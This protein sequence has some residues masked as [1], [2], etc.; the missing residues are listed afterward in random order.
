MASTSIINNTDNNNDINT[1]NDEC[2][3]CCNKY[4]ARKYSKIQC[5]YCNYDMCRQCLEKYLLTTNDFINCMKCKNRWDINFLSKYTSKGF[6][7]NKYKIHR[8]KVL[9]DKE[10]SKIPDIMPCVDSYN[11]IQT[12]KKIMKKTE[13]LKYF[14]ETLEHINNH[15]SFGE[16]NT[17]SIPIDNIRLLD[18]EVDKLM[19]YMN[20]IFVKHIPGLAPP[21]PINV[22]FNYAYLHRGPGWHV[23]PRRITEYKNK[24]R[25]PCPTDNCNSFLDDNYECSVCDCKI[26]KYCNAILDNSNNHVCNK[27]DIE[28]VKN[29]RKHA[30]SCPKCAIPIFKISGCDQMWCTGCKTGF[31]WITGKITNTNIHNPHY[32]NWHIQEQGNG[33]MVIQGIQDNQLNDV[34]CGT[35]PLLTDWIGAINNYFHFDFSY[36]DGHVNY[37]TLTYNQNKNPYYLDIIE[38]HRLAQQFGDNILSKLRRQYN[39]TKETMNFRIKFVLNQIDEKGLKDILIKKDNEGLLLLPQ[40]EIYELFNTV[41]IEIINDVYHTMINNQ[42]NEYDSRI[43]NSKPKTDI[44]KDLHKKRIKI[45]WDK[46]K[47]INKLITYANEQICIV[48]KNNN[49]KAVYFINGDFTNKKTTIS[50]RKCEV[51][52]RRPYNRKGKNGRDYMIYSYISKP[53][54]GTMGYRGRTNCHRD[55]L[56]LGTI[57]ES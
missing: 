21:I 39:D 41:I 44:Q 7:K 22:M 29:I 5:H 36:N 9:Y 37:Y 18:K 25:K 28:S 43:G 49:N 33:N 57:Y 15:Y 3:V 55:H 56:I 10:V 4:T 38:L 47:K 20:N 40:L 2:S 32:Y 27:D 14:Y 42:H 51:N 26:C 30:K 54:G 34:V 8:E 46:L 52:G 13:K 50:T 11:N 53:V 24:Y 23:G 12:I 6:V 45:I 31:S 16:D 17:G 35:L 1:D 19:D 48:S